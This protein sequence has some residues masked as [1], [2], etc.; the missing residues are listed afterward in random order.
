MDYKVYAHNDRMT[1]EIHQKDNY[2]DNVDAIK[3]YYDEGD[4]EE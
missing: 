4:E 3:A 2:H 1:I